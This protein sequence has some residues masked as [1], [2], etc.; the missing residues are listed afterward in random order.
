MELSNGYTRID[1]IEMY[2]RMYGWI[3]AF[4][5]KKLVSIRYLVKI[6]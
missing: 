6:K 3:L 4:G 2:V 5:A 1:I